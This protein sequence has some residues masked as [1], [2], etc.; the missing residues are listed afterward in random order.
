MTEVYH[1]L[2]GG[3]FSQDWSNAGLITADDNWSGVPSI[4]GYRGDDLVTATGVDPRT[5]VTSSAVVDVNANQTN[6]LTFNTGG[7]TEFALANPTIAL[8]GSGTAD[9]PYIVI[10]LNATG[11]QNIV[12]SANILDLESGADNAIQQVAVQYRIG[13]SGNWTNVPDGYIADATIVNATQSTP[14]SV[15]LPSDVDGQAQVQL[16][17]MTTN[18]VGNDEWV[19]VDDINVSS[20][21][22]SGNA[23]VTIGDVSITEGDAGTQIATFTVTR[24]NTAGGFSIDYGTADGSAT[25]GSDYDGA[26]GTLNFTAGGSATQT[27]SVTI[28][29]DTTTEPNETFAVNLTNLVNGTGTATIGDAAATGT[30]TNDDVALVYIHDIQGPAF[31]SPY[32]AGEGITAFNQATVAEVTVRGVVTAVDTIGTLQGFYISE[33]TADWDASMLTSEGIF[34]RT[35]SATAGLT[36]GETVTVTAHVMEFQD[37]TNLNRTILTAPSAIVQSNDSVALPTFVIDGTAGHHIPTAI[38]SD[39]NPVFT[40]STGASGTF[41]PQNDALD[42]Y[43][44]I[45]GMRVTLVDAVVGDGFVGGSND[46]FVYFNAYS[47]ANADQALLNVRGGYTTAGDPE[48]YPVDTIDPNDDVNFGGATVH[49]G[50]THGDVIELDFGNVGCGGTAGFDQLLTMG[51]SLGDVSGIVDFD[52]G[53]AKLFVTDALDQNVIDNLGGTPVQEVTALVGDDRALR[54]ATFNVENL[55]PVGATFSTNNGVEITDA[56]KYTKLAN[57]IATNLNAPDILIIEEIQDNNGV[58]TTGG[59]DAST[60]WGQLVAA[61]NAAT[62]K[63][64]QWVDEAPEVSGDVGGAPGGNIRVGFL[65][66]TARVQLGDLDANATI[67]ERRAYTDRIGDGVR[68]AGDLIAIDDSQVGGINAA[69]WSGTRRSIVGEFKF[70]GQTVYAFGSH[71]PSK[72]GSGEPYQFDQNNSGGQP[73][74]GDWALRNTL[75]ED[76]WSVQ[77]LVSTTL[78]AAS[79]VS[80]GDFNEFWYNRPLEVLTGYATPGGTARVGGTQYSN[81]MVDLLPTVDRFSYDFDGRSQALDTL[82]ADQRLASVASYDVVHISTGYNDRTGAANPASSDHDPS[83]A[84]FD[85]RSFAETLKGTAGDDSLQGFGGDDLIVGGLG[86]DIIDGGSGIDTATYADAASGVTVNLTTGRGTAGEASGDRFTS[87]EN[88][89]GSAFADNLSGNA[90][91]NLINGGAGADLLFGCDGD[92]TLGGGDGAD[93]VRGGNGNDTLTS[94]ADNDVLQGEAGNDNIDGG[95]GVDIVYGGD[96]ADQ[97]QGGLGNDTLR[98][99]TGDDGISGGDGD[100]IIAGDAGVGTLHGDAGNDKVS[101]GADGDT[102]TGDAGDDT[103]GGL[104]GNDLLDGGAGIDTLRGGDGDDGLTGGAD[105]DTLLGEAGID[106]INGDAGSDTLLGGD[107]ADLLDGGADNDT[108]RGGNDG[109]TLTGGIGNDLLLGEAGNDVLTGGIGVDTLLG[110][111]GA[112]MFVF[113]AFGESTPGAGRDIIRDFN[114]GQGDLIDLSAIDSGDADGAFNFVGSFSG[115]AGE[116]TTSVVGAFS[117]VLADV[118]GDAVADFA[119]LATVAGGG[120]LIQADFIL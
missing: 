120:A 83:L 66:D 105:A 55:S 88:L 14:L 114:R 76:V 89:T 25:A 90:F 109:D 74:N 94:G 79:V 92:D 61:V 23:S 86:A 82:I 50:A 40:D 102:I 47:A 48:F 96:G 93:S 116:L 60:T 28:H 45:E 53:V 29:G 33:E 101:G 51:D 63:T 97:I 115:T 52:F 24:S 34:V 75:A 84:S 85:F 112:D 108:L 81:L 26:S 67:E 7:V 58:T 4:V 71:L 12:F 110:G 72:G 77:N 39:D 2:S 68:T 62:G 35:T 56:A 20:S 99:G 69:D 103:L 87:V 65:Y 104:G 78:P 113:T 73:A 80:G 42:F 59:T 30:I 54:V 31:F 91:V 117:L 3:S 95:D 21:P 27:I 37:F 119:F 36:V 9:A 32:V 13:S 107:G 43:E 100:D 10:H 22:V 41:N 1:D 17:V 11:R 38:I 98:G 57:H 19:G 64:Y 46:D 6:P 70:N 118:D 5:I 111:A 106:T 16:R 8:T 49:D 44:T 18:A 15:T